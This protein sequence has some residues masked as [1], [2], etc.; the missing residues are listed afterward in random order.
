MLIIRLLLSVWQRFISYKI[1]YYQV[2][3]IGKKIIK[4]SESIK[5]DY[6]DH[7]SGL[8]K[9]EL[10][11]LKPFIKEPWKEFTF[12]NVKEITKNTSKHYVFEALKNFT[13]LNLITETKRGKTNV[14]QL[15][16]T[17]HELQ[18][19]ALTESIIKEQRNDIPYK[20]LQ[21]ITSKIK[22]PFYILLIG[23]SYADGKQTAK[24]DLDVAFIIPDSENK[25]LYQV[26][27][28]EGELQVPEVHGYVFTK[29]EFYQMLV[30]Q[31]FNFGKELAKKHIIVSS[32]ESYYKILF[33]AMRNGFKG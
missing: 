6:I 27:L 14:Y 31:E 19:I 16:I 17:N 18:Y 3:K 28:K 29:D 22:N 11:I 26:A 2:I 32:V 25:K 7:K 30:N 21:Q 9:N 20:N 1:K 23:G 4:T 15:N 24:S 12:A 8:I 5:V 13:K 33:E 10:L